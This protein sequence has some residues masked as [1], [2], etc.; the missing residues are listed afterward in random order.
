MVDCDFKIKCKIVIDLKST[1]NRLRLW[2]RIYTDF[3][4]AISK[5]IL[6][7]IGFKGIESIEDLV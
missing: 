7:N 4:P 5:A 1:V 2:T 3:A 6:I